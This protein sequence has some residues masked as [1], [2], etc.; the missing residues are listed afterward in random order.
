M[1]TT[2]N[3]T[4]EQKAKLAKTANNLF[5]S[6]TPSLRFMRILHNE[7][8]IIC[9]DDLNS[10]DEFYNMKSEANKP[11]RELLNTLGFKHTNFGIAVN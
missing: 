2:L 7:Y 4:Q 6:G 3:L 11:M 8:Q 1:T 5:E 10:P 9:N